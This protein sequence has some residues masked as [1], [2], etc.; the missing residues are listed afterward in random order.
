MNVVKKLSEMDVIKKLSIEWGE[1]PKSSDLY[2]QLFQLFPLS[3]FTKEKEYKRGLKM[4]SALLE[5]LLSV[6]IADKDKKEIEKY[7]DSLTLFIE[8]YEKEKFPHIGKDTSDIDI[9]EYLMEE[10]DLT[11]QDLKNELGSQS[12]VSEILH[13]KRKLN[14]KQIEALSKRFKISPSVFFRIGEVNKED[15]QQH[16]ADAPADEIKHRSRKNKHQ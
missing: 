7:L 13:K 12:I 15:L 8:I 11:Q 3:T 16:E 5:V 2:M 9:L 6:N 14:R 1:Q 4:S 10:H